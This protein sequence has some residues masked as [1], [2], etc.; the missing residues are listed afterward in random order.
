[1]I[2]FLLFLSCSIFLLTKPLV[3]QEV[4]AP[5][6][7]E[8][9]EL[10]STNTYT[11]STIHLAISATTPFPIGDQY[12]WLIR[13]VTVPTDGQRSLEKLKGEV[14]LSREVHPI[15]DRTIAFN[16]NAN[17]IIYAYLI[18]RDFV[19]DELIWSLDEQNIPPAIKKELANTAPAA[20]GLP[21]KTLL[22]PDG[23]DL[24]GLVFNQTRTRPGRE[25]FAIFS[26]NW[27]PPTQTEA[28]WITIKEFPTPGRFTL[29]SVSLNNRELLQ[30]FLQPR[31]DLMENLVV[32]TIQTLQSILSQGE[33]EGLF[34][35]QD[36][37]GKTIENTEVEK[38]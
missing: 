36:L 34:S 9:P 25:F 17:T 38:F 27:H 21:K 3:G 22:A 29:I 8:F 33:I 6:A 23:F 30:R 37:H 16:Q 19:V 4:I 18:D 24:G 10:R 1:M 13:V 11:D 7:L 32:E 12:H 5:D 35:E 28:Y 26:Q 15:F 20:H 2:R 14:I 31:R